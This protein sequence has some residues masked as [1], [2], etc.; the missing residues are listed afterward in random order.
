MTPWTEPSRLLCPWVFPSKNTGVGCYF[1]LQEIFPTQ[2]SNLG[3]LH[4]RQILYHL[5][6]QGSLIMYLSAILTRDA[7]VWNH[8]GYF[9]SLRTH[10]SFPSGSDSKESP[11]NAGDLSLTPGLGR[12]PEEGNGNPLQYSC[13]EHPMDRGAWWA[14]VHGVAKSQTR[15]NS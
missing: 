2:G 14:T 13:L 9:L 11:A 12:Y 7:Y 15:L 4:C 6:H 5:S 1:L 3:F 8:T 10:V